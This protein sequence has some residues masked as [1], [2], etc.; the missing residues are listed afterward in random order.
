[1]WFT[2]RSNAVMNNNSFGRFDIVMLFALLYLLFLLTWK[3]FVCLVAHI[4]FRCGCLFFYFLG[5]ITIQ[6]EL[7]HCNGY[8]LRMKKNE[9]NDDDDDDNNLFSSAFYP[10]RIVISCNGFHAIL[11]ATNKFH[12][13]LDESTKVMF[14]TKYMEYFHTILKFY[15]AIFYAMLPK[16]STEST[17][18]FLFKNCYNHFFLVPFYKN[19]ECRQMTFVTC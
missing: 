12:N 3:Q 5:L 16:K 19:Y 15:I 2:F 13:H 6:H 14:N 1:M 7:I 9:D 4:F 11:M 18:Y 8:S 10:S 17:Q